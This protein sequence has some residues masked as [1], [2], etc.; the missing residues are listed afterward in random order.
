MLAHGIHRLVT[1][2]SANFERYQDISLEPIPAVDLD[3]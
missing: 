1:Y 3:S 2:N